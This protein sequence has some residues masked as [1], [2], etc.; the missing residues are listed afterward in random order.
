MTGSRPIVS[1][2]N[3]SLHL[4]ARRKLFSKAHTILSGLDL[5][6]YPQQTLGLIGRNGSGKTT[7]LRV[8]AA[9]LAQTHDPS[10]VH[11]YALD[12]ASRGLGSL[13]ALPHV[14][15][16]IAG[17]DT[18]RVQ[19]MIGTLE[20]EI[21]RRRDR[22]GEVGVSLLS[23]YQRVQPDDPMARIVVL[24]DGYTSFA[25]GKSP[26]WNQYGHERMGWS[27]SVY[28]TVSP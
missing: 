25:A 1:L 28:N 27:L 22:F 26:I 6:L 3:V 7:L 24:L 2:R 9:S 13:D 12:F 17:T 19:R 23:E 11:L 16:V 4:R 21:D 8:I 15:A 18:E 20:S 14:G 10:Q 5:D